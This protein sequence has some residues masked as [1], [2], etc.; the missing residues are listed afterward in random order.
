MA[1]A[2]LEDDLKCCICWNMFTDP[3]TLTCGHTFCRICVQDLLFNQDPGGV[4]SCPHCRIRFGGRPVIQRNTAL[5]NV[6]ERIRSN[7]QQGDLLGT[8]SLHRRP[9]EYYCSEDAA[10]ICTLCREA[11]QHR[12]HEILTLDVA[13]EKKKEALRNVLG[14]L[15]TSDEGEKKAQNLQEQMIKVKDEASTVRTSVTVLCQEFRTQLNVLERRTLG[16]ISGQEKQVSS[17]M[18]QK[19]KEIDDDHYSK[20]L[21]LE[22]LCNMTDNL[23][24][25]QADVDGLTL[26]DEGE[27]GA[28]SGLD[29]DLILETF[30]TGIADVVA[31]VT[32]GTYVHNA[33]GMTLNVHT[34]GSSIYL[35][36][37]L[38][39]ASWSER[40]LNHPETPER[41]EYNQVLSRK[42]FCKGRQFW[43]VETSETGNWMIGMAYVS[44]E[45]IGSGSL[46]GDNQ[47]SWC[48]RR[49][50]NKYSVSHDKR[51]SDLPFEPSKSAF[52]IYLDYEAGQMSFYELGPPTRHL[53]TF[54]ASFMEPLHAVIWVWSSWVRIRS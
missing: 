10:R 17:T 45:R 4:Y 34:A 52:R 38:K 8:C 30:H 29:E 26:V 31:C 23:T 50:D 18:S 53:Y 1:Y 2:E 20:V 41:F 32:G 28:P 14:H 39:T 3:T 43:D 40:N 46:V 19:L 35:S 37:D 7:H 15:V 16:L 9:L 13:C 22:E 12:G 42:T 44:I 54:T 21:Y 11:T 27:D 33:I 51:I 47:K 48:L 5:C 24:L 36:T 25:L 49:F 6:V